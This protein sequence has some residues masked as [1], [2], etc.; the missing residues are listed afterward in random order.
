MNNKL[1]WILPIVINKKRI[2]DVNITD[3]D[4]ISNESLANLLSNINTEI[5]MWKSNQSINEQNKYKYFINK[6][7]ELFKP[8]YDIDLDTVDYLYNMH[9]NNNFDFIVDNLGDLKNEVRTMHFR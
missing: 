4:N 1:M 3:I 8:F 6:V 7:S 2:Y 9:I 5:E